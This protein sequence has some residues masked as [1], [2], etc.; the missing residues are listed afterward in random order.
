MNLLEI[1]INYWKFILMGILNSDFQKIKLP[2]SI[3]YFYFSIFSK[4]LYEDSYYKTRL[5]G[6]IIWNVM[7]YMTLVLQAQEELEV[8]RGTVGKSLACSLKICNQLWSFPSRRHISETR[9][10]GK[11]AFSEVKFPQLLCLWNVSSAWKRP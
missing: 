6:K 11:F 2:I 4:S 1:K 8:E 10:S 7:V 9:K 3:I 5:S